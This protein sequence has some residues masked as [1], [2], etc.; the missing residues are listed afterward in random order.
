MARRDDEDDDAVVEDRDKVPLSEKN[1]RVD[2]DRFGASK[3]VIAGESG[4]ELGPRR[5]L[6]RCKAPSQRV[7]G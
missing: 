2:E 6:R 7:H 5:S 1:R 4:G 3:L